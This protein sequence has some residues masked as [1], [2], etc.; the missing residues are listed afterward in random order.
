MKRQ[1]KKKERQNRHENQPALPRRKRTQLA[2]LPRRQTGNSGNS[3]WV[4]CETLGVSLLRR[5]L[6]ASFSLFRSFYYVPFVFLFPCLDYAGTLA[7]ATLLC[8]ILFYFLAGPGLGPVSGCALNGAGRGAP[9]EKPP[10]K[11]EE[12]RTKRPRKIQKYP[13]ISLGGRNA[14]L[15]ETAIGYMRGRGKRKGGDEKEE[16][17]KKKK[18]KEREKKEQGK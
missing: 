13:L 4:L 15:L 11:M 7:S 17:I 12:A 3:I 14:R 8:F 2:L 16:E 5:Y 18:K 6:R 10:K 1:K 9:K